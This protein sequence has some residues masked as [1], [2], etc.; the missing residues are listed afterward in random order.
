MAIDLSALFG[1]QPDYSQLLSPAETQKM[2]SGANQSAL[3]NA[4]IALLGSS[5]QTR[6]PISTGQA[7]GGALGAGLEGYNQSFDRNLKQMLTGMQLGE[8]KR[9]QQAELLKQ[10]E[11]QQLKD[12]IRGGAIPKYGTA[13]AVIPTETYED[14]KTT[15]P[16]LVGF[17]YDLQKIIP[18]LQAT[19][20]FAAIKDISDSMTSLRKAGFMSGDAQAPSPFAPYTM[21]ESP[22]V[23]TLANQLQTAYN[24]GVITE[25]QAYQRLQP[26]AQMEESFQKFKQTSA[27]AAAKAAE[28]KKPTESE[29]KAAT[30][31]GRLE[32]SLKD[33]Q[34]IKQ[35]A[36]KPEVIPSLLQG[37]S[38][39]PGAEMLAGKISSEDRLRAEAAQ[40]DALDAALTLGT[41]AA[42]TREQLRGYAKSYFPQIGDTPNV[43]A[44]KN[45][46]FE[47]LVSLAREQAGTA[48]KRIDTA[49]EKAKPFNPNQFKKDRGLE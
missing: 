41:G 12:I 9:K 7:L 16:K 29:A 49:T 13:E 8:I 3:L 23:K 42:Y 11:A 21:A 19:G 20:N 32:G 35:E 46:R 36:L 34:G 31:A 22:Q 4:A 30:L 43:I 25:E 37:L 45:T 28:G 18:Q 48:G 5:G 10:Q 33:L 47:R 24:R 39:V 38:I 15:V 14:V 44:E 6:Q 27:E 26:L 17:D 2:Q 40:L 1:Q